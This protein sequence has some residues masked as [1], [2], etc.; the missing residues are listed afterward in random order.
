MPSARPLAAAVLIALAACDDPAVAPDADPVISQVAET[1]FV[2]TTEPG[3]DGVVTLTERWAIAADSARLG[4]IGAAVLGVDGAV[5]YATTG[6]SDQAVLYRNQQDGDHRAIALRGS[7]ATELDGPLLL[8][9]LADGGLV[10]IEQRTGRGIRYDSLGGVGATLA[11]P[12]LAGAVSVTADRNGGWF[13]RD[14]ASEAWWHHA[15]DGRLTDTVRAAPGWDGALAI[16]PDGSLLRST[17]G[18][19]QLERRAGSGPILTS[20]WEGAVLVAPVAAAHDA[21]GLAWVGDAST[22][23]AFDRDGQLRFRVQVGAGEALVDRD[24]EFLLFRGADGGLRVVEA[25]SPEP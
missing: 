3:L 20:R 18:L 25:S 8:A 11:M 5:W 1:T 16:G 12:W 2:T 23:R 9:A 4:A 21:Q 17:A 22:W 13:A 14:A 7:A 10:A 6:G 19:R 24:G 15:P